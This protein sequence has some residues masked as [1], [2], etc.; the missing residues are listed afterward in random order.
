MTSR[1][2]LRRV[3]EDRL[4]EVLRQQIALQ[5]SVAHAQAAPD[6]LSVDAH[7]LLSRRAEHLAASVRDFLD[8]DFMLSERVWMS[9]HLPDDLASSI[10]E[11]E[12]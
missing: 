8:V 11:N 6:G 5:A 2:A 12:R 7:A 3:R 9:E 1:D 10:E 4:L